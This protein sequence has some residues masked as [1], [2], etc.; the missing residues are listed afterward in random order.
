MPEPT[1]KVTIQYYAVLREQRG[2][3]HEAIK[4]EASTA[5]DVYRELQNRY[6]FHL[7]PEFLKVAVNGEFRP[8][9][10]PIHDA[11]TLVFIPPVAGG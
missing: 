10:S 5:L 1:K 11:D 6:G 8:L 3:S 4:T 9:E 7:A 2:L